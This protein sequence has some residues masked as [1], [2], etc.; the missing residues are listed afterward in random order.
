MLETVNQGELIP[1]LQQ[2]WDRLPDESSVW[3]SRFVHYLILP[4]HSVLGAYVS[5]CKQTEPERTAE[6]LADGGI[7]APPPHWY[8]KAEQYHWQEKANGKRV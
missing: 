2:A 7:K 5:Y 8:E 1:S 6:R 3:Y 4:S